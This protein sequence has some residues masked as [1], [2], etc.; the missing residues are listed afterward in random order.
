V[1]QQTTA[2]GSAAAQSPNILS[3]TLAETIGIVMGIVALFVAFGKILW[4]ANQNPGGP[5]LDAR[6]TTQVRAAH[7]DREWIERLEKAY[8]LGGLQ[9]K[10]AIDAL[11][12]VLS[13]IAPL[14]G[15]A[16][17][18]E[19]LKLL[20]DVQKPGPDVPLYDAQ[21]P[22]SFAKPVDTGGLTPL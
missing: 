16:V 12:G 14:T 13:N 9:A 18:D 10:T 11:A 4:D 22:N 8:A 5:S 7:E 20:R 1:A 6:L 15:L 3:L 17:D 2:A 19:A 21:A